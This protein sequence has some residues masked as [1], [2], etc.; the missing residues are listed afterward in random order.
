ML[1]KLKSARTAVLASIAG[2]LLAPAAW[3]VELTMYYPVAVG[4]PLT[5]VVDG[6]VADFMKE[7]PDIEVKA[8]YAGI[9]PCV[10]EDIWS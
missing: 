3:A 2:L 10:Q 8:I 5:K 7:N 1:G 9:G 6:L 4:G